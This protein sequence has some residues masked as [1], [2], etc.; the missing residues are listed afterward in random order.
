MEAQKREDEHIEKPLLVELPEKNT[1]IHFDLESDSSGER[2]PMR[3]TATCPDTVQRRPFR[4]KTF[5]A[6]RQLRRIALHITGQCRPCAFF[7]FRAD[8]CRL[9][10]ECKYCHLCTKE[11]IREWK[12]AYAARKR[13]CGA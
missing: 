2:L 5:I 13:S 3:P 12:K 7:A 9:G 4:T 6:K 1:F 8:S 11:D 10:E